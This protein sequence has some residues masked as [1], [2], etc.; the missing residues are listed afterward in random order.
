MWR[1]QDL[2]VKLRN[3]ASLRMTLENYQSCSEPNSN[4]SKPELLI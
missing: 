1:K 4:L 2:H 3:M